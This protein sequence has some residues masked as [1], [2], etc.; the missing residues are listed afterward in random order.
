MKKL[1]PHPL[2]SGFKAG[3]EGE[4]ENI[5]QFHSQTERVLVIVGQR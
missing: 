4:E 3:K 5:H 1:T 2:S